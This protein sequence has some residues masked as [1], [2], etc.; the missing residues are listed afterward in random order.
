MDKYLYKNFPEFY[1]D[2]KLCFNPLEHGIP[3]A[4]IAPTEDDRALRHQLLRGYVHDELCAWSGGVEGNAGLFGSAT[5]LYPVLQMFL[6]GGTYNGKRYVNAITV[7][8]MTTQKSHISRRGLGFDKPE[9]DPKKKLKMNPC[10]EECSTATYGHS[11]YTGTCF[12][13]DPKHELIYIFLC[14]RIN[15]HRWNTT[16]GE[17][18]YRQRIQSLIYEAI[19]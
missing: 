19:K 5:Q 11:G 9:F 12:W 3:L 4:R 17:E 1:G 6:N 15:P 18:N 13:I 10:C 2:E 7:E 16:L 8:R 14:N